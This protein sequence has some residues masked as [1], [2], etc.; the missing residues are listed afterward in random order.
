MIAYKGHSTVPLIVIPSLKAPLGD[1]RR[2]VEQF[3]PLELQRKSSEQS[4][5]NLDP[6][7]M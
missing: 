1:S 2:W 4:G 5:S 6:Y 3:L 7:W